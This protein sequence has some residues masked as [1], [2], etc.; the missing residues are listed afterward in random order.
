M[1]G[2]WLYLSFGHN[3]IEWIYVG[4]QNVSIWHSSHE[5]QLSQQIWIKLSSTDQNQN[6]TKDP[7]ATECFIGPSA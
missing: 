7:W 6:A 3:F 4:Q 5:V 1:D 2:E